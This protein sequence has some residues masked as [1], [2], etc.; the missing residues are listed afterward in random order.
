MNAKLI[1]EN[2][3]NRVDNILSIAHKNIVTSVNINMVIA[4]WLIRREIVIELQA[5]KKRAA[6]GKKI[7]EDLSQKLNK[8]Y[9]Q[10]FSI[11]NLQ[12]FRKFY[13][14]FSDRITI[15]HPLGAEFK[16]DNQFSD[17]CNNSSG[18]AIMHSLGAEFKRMKIHSFSP[19][20]S[21]SHYRAL[22]KSNDKKAR[23]F[24]EDEA[25]ACGWNKRDLERNKVIC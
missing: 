18:L 11:R 5:G 16:D 2:L 21:W 10:G 24:Y 6:Y 7:I 3:F 1:E 25:I 13:T 20:L 23:Q 9:K 12:Y 8:K 4:Y 14:V 17:N 15:S 19:Q 22:L